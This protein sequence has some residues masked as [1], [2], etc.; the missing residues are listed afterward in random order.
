MLARLESRL[1]LLTGGARDAPAR[2]QTLRST[3]GWSHDLL[4]LVEVVIVT[5]P[6]SHPSL[7]LVN[8]NYVGPTLQHTRVQHGK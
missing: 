6:P 4:E 2:Q 7:L 8:P 1:Q 5:S 3:I